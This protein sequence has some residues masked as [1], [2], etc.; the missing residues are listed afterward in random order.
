MKGK[1]K[2]GE[3]GGEERGIESLDGKGGLGSGVERGEV[4]NLKMYLFFLLCFRSVAHSCTKTVNYISKHTY[5]QCTYVQT[6]ASF[7]SLKNT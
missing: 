3:K 2:G 6:M 1:G 4:S 5:V 7:A